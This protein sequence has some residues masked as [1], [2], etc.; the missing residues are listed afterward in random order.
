MTFN[1]FGGIIFCKNGKIMLKI[2]LKTDY[3][4]NLKL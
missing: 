3:R 2:K 1:L 4:G